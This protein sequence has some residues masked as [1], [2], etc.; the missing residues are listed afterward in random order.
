MDHALFLGAKTMREGGLEAPTRHAPDWRN[1]AFYHADYGH[2][3]VM[4]HEVREA[5]GGDFD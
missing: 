3:T 5:L 4:A 2:M 1:P